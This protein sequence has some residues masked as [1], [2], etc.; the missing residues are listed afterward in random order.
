MTSLKVGHKMLSFRIMLMVVL[1]LMLGLLNACGSSNVDGTD[2]IESAV[3]GGPVEGDQGS[4]GGCIAAEFRFSP[5]DISGSCC[6]VDGSAGKFYPARSI[7][8]ANWFACDVNAVKVCSKFSTTDI[9][10]QLCICNGL[11]SDFKVSAFN[12]NYYLCQ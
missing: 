8:N 9:R 3:T 10:G 5:T 7:D 1:S 2:V 11:W 6:A 12:T 4:G